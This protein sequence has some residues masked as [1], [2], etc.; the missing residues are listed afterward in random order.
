MSL[1]LFP[2]MSGHTKRTRICWLDPANLIS[3][4]YHDSRF[5]G[6]RDEKFVKLVGGHR[7]LRKKSRFF[8]FLIP[9]DRFAWKIDFSQCKI[10]FS[11]IFW[12]KIAYSVWRGCNSKPHGANSVQCMFQKLSVSFSWS[13]QKMLQNGGHESFQVGLWTFFQ[14]H[15]CFSGMKP[16]STQPSNKLWIPVGYLPECFLN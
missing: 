9:P 3:L 13:M 15:V 14:I 10:D 1:S 16:K 2:S 11:N 12:S 4:G 6:G 5:R 7:H 8:D